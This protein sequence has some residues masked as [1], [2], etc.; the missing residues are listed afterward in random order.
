MTEE[1]CAVCG[2]EFQEGEERVEVY[3][4]GDPVVCCWGPCTL[5]M[6]DEEE[7]LEWLKAGI[8]RGTYW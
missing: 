4:G 6:D 2:R 1:R 3:R 5:M 8:R 7:E